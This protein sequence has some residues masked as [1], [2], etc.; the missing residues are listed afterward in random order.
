[1]SEFNALFGIRFENVFEELYKEMLSTGCAEEEGG[2]LKLTRKG[3]L[4]RDLIARQFFSKEVEAAES[5]Y[6]TTA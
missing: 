1:M 6:R 3:L 5:A 2:K 4:F